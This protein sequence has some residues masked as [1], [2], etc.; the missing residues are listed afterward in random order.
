MA[1]QQ[2]G[3]QYGDYRIL[4]VMQERVYLMDVTGPW[5]RLMSVVGLYEAID[6]WRKRLIHSFI[7]TVKQQLTKRNCKYWLEN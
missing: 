7:K 4:V 3:P 1:A 6:Q 5:Q 2:P